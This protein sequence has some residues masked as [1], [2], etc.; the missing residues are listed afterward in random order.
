MN[1][2]VFYFISGSIL[3]LIILILP[4]KTV[5]QS[6][7]SLGIIGISANFPQ[8]INGDTAYEDSSYAFISFQIANLDTS[9][10]TGNLYIELHVDTGGGLLF[11]D[12][13]LLS[14]NPVTIPGLGTALVFDSSVYNFSGSKYKA[15][16]NIV[17]VW[18][19]LI[20]GTIAI[21]DSLQTEVFFVPST[22]GISDLF[23]AG[24]LFYLYPNPAN[25][26]IEVI[27][28]NKK[29]IEGVRFYDLRGRLLKDVMY[30]SQSKLDVRDLSN[31]CYFLELILNNQRKFATKFMKL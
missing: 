20:G 15:G 5:A 30:L 3:L 11:A 24:N 2:K 25:D 13:I 7:G 12:S 1:T 4:L 27:I 19:K 10:F 31:G 9:L 18:P 21:S 26:F 6:G 28:K 16:S 8:V 17:V 23:E 22:T 29:D 14:S